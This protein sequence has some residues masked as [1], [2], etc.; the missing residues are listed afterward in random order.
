MSQ[1]LLASRS[2]DILEMLE[3]RLGCIHLDPNAEHWANLEL[4]ACPVPRGGFW[5][6]RQLHWV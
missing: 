1:W 6:C 5:I 4:H 3:R 2:T